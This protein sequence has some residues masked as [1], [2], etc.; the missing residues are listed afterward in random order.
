[1]QRLAVLPDGGEPVGRDR[2]ERPSDRVVHGAG[3]RGAEHPHAGWRAGR[4]PGGDRLR[5][6]TGPRRLAREHLVRHRGERIEI[7]ARIERP[8]ARCLLGAHVGR[9]ADGHARPGE[10]VVAGHRARDP[11][12]GHQRRPVAG[13]QNVLGLDVAV[14]DA[15]PVRVLE[16]ARRLGGDAERVL[17][18][19]LPLAVEPLAQRLALDER[20][21]EPE[22]AG[23]FAGVVHGQDVRMLEA[24][25]ESDLALKALG[26]ERDGELG[27][28]DLE[29]DRT[30]V[31]EVVREIDDGHPAAAELALERIAVGK[32]I[33]EVDRHA[34]GGSWSLGNSR[35]GTEGQ[36]K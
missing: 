6:G 23:G 31:T 16:R 4:P 18:R 22:L 20:H 21:G 1:M 10:P 17:H 5:R 25:G 28:E 2:R 35:S 19:K 13:E 32:G 11:E 27:P 33:S 36:G 34:H 30:F 9:R 3:H 15:V 29:R 26:A 7:G 14:H 8:L 24:R 12:V